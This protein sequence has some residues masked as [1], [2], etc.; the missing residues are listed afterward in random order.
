MLRSA[1]V[2]TTFMTADKAFFVDTNVLLYS[3]D[4]A[5]PRKQECATRWTLALWESGAGRTS[6]QV[7]NEFYANATG[8]LKAKPRDIRSVVEA[9]AQWQPVGFDLDLLQRAWNWADRASLSYWDALILGAAE[10]SGCRYL[11]S[12]DFQEDRTFGGVQIL[13]P[14]HSAPASL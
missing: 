11:L 14:F 2:A 1:P 3:L 12:E 6:W 4:A 5:N 8:K 9:Y 10:H 7:L 13:N